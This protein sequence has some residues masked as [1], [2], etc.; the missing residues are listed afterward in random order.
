M[1]W[2]TNQSQQS[3]LWL[4]CRQH[5]LQKGEGERK[6]ERDRQRNRERERKRERQKETERET[7]TGRG[8][9][10]P[11]L[12]LVMIWIVRDEASPGGRKVRSQ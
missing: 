9:L 1:E 8:S 10:K 6:T 7:D 5:S 11:A 2:A 3:N 12:R 4:N